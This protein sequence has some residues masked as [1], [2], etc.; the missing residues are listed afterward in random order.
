MHIQ[1]SVQA[2]SVQFM[3]FSKVSTPAWAVC[4]A[5]KG[6]YLT[7]A[8]AEAILGSY[9]SSNA[10]PTIH[11]EPGGG[12]LQGWAGLWPGEMGEQNEIQEVTDE[13][14]NQ[15]ATHR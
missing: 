6:V 10:S 14:K 8:S 1:K 11:R 5:F 3:N 4:S 15:A 13:A 2:V 12:K 9:I 7:L